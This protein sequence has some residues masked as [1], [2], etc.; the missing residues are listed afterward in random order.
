[1]DQ[2]VTEKAVIFTQLTL[3]NSQNI[4]AATCWRVRVRMCHVRVCARVRVC[5]MLVR[6]LSCLPRGCVCAR[7]RAPA[8]SITSSIAGEGGEGGEGACGRTRDHQH[9]LRIGVQQAPVLD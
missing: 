5:Q 7:W 8:S 4:S 6:V 2:Q 9:H 3:H 1:M